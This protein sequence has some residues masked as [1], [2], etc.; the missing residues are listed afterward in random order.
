MLTY[1]TARTVEWNEWMLKRRPRRCRVKEDVW[2]VERGKELEL[3]ADT[4]RCWLRS[5]QYGIGCVRGSRYRSG[6]QVSSQNRRVGN[7]ED[8]YEAANRRRNDALF[9]FFRNLAATIAN[10]SLGLDIS[11]WVERKSGRKVFS[12]SSIPGK[13]CE[14]AI[15]PRAMLIHYS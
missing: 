9:S 11:K 13:E 12:S 4:G 2:Y 5:L 7:P 14:E 6:D 10:S 15:C 8:G 1:N 3:K